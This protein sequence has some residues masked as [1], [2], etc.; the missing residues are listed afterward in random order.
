M[1]QR[2]PAQ[3]FQYDPLDLTN[4]NAK[5]LVC[6][7]SE[8]RDGLFDCEFWHNEAAIEYSTVTY[9]EDCFSDDVQIFLNGCLRKIKRTLS[10]F[11]TVAR[12]LLP[13][14]PFFIDAIS[15][16]ENN[17][18]EMVRQVKLAPQIYS[19]ASKVYIWLGPHDFYTSHAIDILGKELWDQELLVSYQSV[20]AVRFWVGLCEMLLNR[21]WRRAE[22]MQEFALPPRG[23]IMQGEHFLSLDKFINKSKKI[24][25]YLCKNYDKTNK[26]LHRGFQ[27]MLRLSGISALVE[28]RESVQDPASSEQASPEQASQIWRALA[29]QPDIYCNTIKKRIWS[30]RSF[31]KHGR[32]FDVNPRLNPFELFLEC[33]WLDHDSEDIGTHI[34]QLARLLDLSPA[35]I[36][37]YTRETGKSFH[38][39]GTETDGVASV[40]NRSLHEQSSV[41]DDSWRVWE[42][43]GLSGP[44]T[45]PGPYYVTTGLVDL[46]WVNGRGGSDTFFLPQKCHL[47][48]ALRAGPTN[49]FLLL[50]VHFTDNEVGSR[51]K[52][53]AT[54]LAAVQCQ[55]ISDDAFRA[56]DIRCCCELGIYETQCTASKMTIYYALIDGSVYTQGELESRALKY[57]N[58]KSLVQNGC[59]MMWKTPET[60]STTPLFEL[61]DALAEDPDPESHA[62]GILEDRESR[63]DTRWE[64][65]IELADHKSSVRK[66]TFSPDGRILASY[67]T[68]NT[69]RLLDTTTGLTKRLLKGFEGRSNSLAISADSK[70]LAHDLRNG[71][72][73]IWRLATEQICRNLVGL[74]RWGQVTAIA[75][76]PN[77]ELI[78]SSNI[79]QSKIR[80][81][82]LMTTDEPQL[83]EDYGHYAAVTTLDFS[84]DGTLLASGSVDKSLLIWGLTSARLPRRFM[85][86]TGTVVS[87]AFSPDSSLVASASPDRTIRVWLLE[88]EIAIH[89]LRGHEDA[90]SSVCFSP[91][92]TLIVSGSDDG[93]LR[94]WDVKT[95][96][97]LHKL[98]QHR[99]AIKSVAFSP[100]GRLIASGSDDS[101][102]RLWGVKKIERPSILERLDIHSNELE[103]EVAYFLRK[104][105][106]L[107][108]FLDLGGGRRSGKAKSKETDEE[109]HELEEI[110]DQ[111]NR[112]PNENL[113]RRRTYSASSHS[114]LS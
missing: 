51:I 80:L 19:M 99:N 105:S 87:V 27:W 25:S 16:D 107:S 53:S 37:I 78:A 55:D 76:S 3:W 17:E 84:P 1:T 70:L 100:K 106:D 23:Q 9:N 30:M 97:T 61:S 40:E 86:H 10:E 91:C 66:V 56:Q 47:K 59:S 48:I 74:S 57:F 93:T 98:V 22:T 21:Y 94:I 42:S 102:V 26:D 20:D 2:P 49:V 71:E 77:S 85:G 58:D 112:Q 50:G 52:K 41:S 38:I 68:D 43:S 31:T 44:K 88:T 95:G 90:A 81:W 69:I 33:I 35:G 113:T 73:Q 65:S 34:G 54:T 29:A 75:F 28:L 11:L 13:Q 18:E 8:L 82:N 39:P 114:E 72:I 6:I 62:V 32:M 63:P 92:G 108:D 89:T 7:N 67:S 5:R 24:S 109:E 111:S 45:E 36:L 103:R 83:L 64:D 96:N 4:P 46:N 60:T 104:F 15:V 79:N 14:Q 110:V 101:T 12:V